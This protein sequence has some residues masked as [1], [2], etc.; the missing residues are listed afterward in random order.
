MNNDNAS[1]RKYYAFISYNSKDT[2]LGKRLQRKLEHYRMPATLCSE[3]GWKRKP[4]DPVF[5]APYEIQPGGLSEELKLR[6]R[7]S[8]NLVVICSPNSAKSDWVGK[9]IE[10]FHELGRDENILFFIVD[11]VP[12]SGDTATECFNP[13]VKKLGLPETLGANIHERI[14][15]WPWINRERAYVQLISKLLGVEFDS[16]WQRL[17]E[18]AYAKHLSFLNNFQNDSAAHY[19]EK[20]AKLVPENIQYQLEA[21]LFISDYLAK[22][23]LAL[24]YYNKALTFAKEKYGEGHPDVATSYNNIGGVY[25]SQGDYAKALENYERS[26][27]IRLGIFGE[28]HPDVATSFNNIGAIYNSQGDYER[29]LE[30]YEKALKICLE[31]LGEDHPYVKTVKDSI[32]VVKKKMEWKE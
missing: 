17:A 16:I 6:L 1:Q 11:G 9:E 3:R 19:L 20:R 31:K 30:N 12:G 21:G 26:L 2:R 8:K 10:Y 15:R 24:E 29:A 18:L 14:F 7:N 27:K 23:D 4:M 5:F 28:D 22:Y 25:D 32:E 13:V